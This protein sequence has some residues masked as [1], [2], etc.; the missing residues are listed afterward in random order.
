MTD[1]DIRRYSVA[2]QHFVPENLTPCINTT[3]WKYSL[4]CFAY[5]G[6]KI[7]D[8]AWEVELVFPAVSLQENFYHFVATLAHLFVEWPV[9]GWEECYSKWNDQSIAKRLVNI[10][11]DQKAFKNFG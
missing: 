7:R 6:L 4:L 10:I 5:L 8:E 2:Y 1:K 11:A 9:Q 3:N